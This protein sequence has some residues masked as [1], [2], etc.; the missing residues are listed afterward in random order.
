MSFTASGKNVVKPLKSN[1]AHN[2]IKW[3]FEQK[4][5]YNVCVGYIGKSMDDAE[6][7][8]WKTLDGVSKSQNVDYLFTSTNMEEANKKFQEIISGKVEK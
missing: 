4:D 3:D 5:S 2:C 7:R 8:I 6:W 1:F